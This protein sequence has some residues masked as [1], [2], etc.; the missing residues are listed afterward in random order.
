MKWLVAFAVLMSAVARPSEGGQV[1]S[2]GIVLSLNVMG[3]EQLGDYL[4]ELRL[5]TV[6]PFQTRSG[7][8]LK[9]PSFG[10][11]LFRLRPG[12]RRGCEVR[13]VSAH[14]PRSTS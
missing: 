7:T 5:E 8:V 14:R 4:A 13:S 3:L 9:I 1:A 12:T 11:V 2:D 6:F 10:S